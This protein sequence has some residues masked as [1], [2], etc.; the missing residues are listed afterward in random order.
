[1]LK[2]EMRIG[3]CASG[4]MCEASSEDSGGKGGAHWI[5]TASGNNGK[6]NRPCYSDQDN[7]NYSVAYK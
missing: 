1:M 2:L 4:F 3:T 7:L 6:D 5:K